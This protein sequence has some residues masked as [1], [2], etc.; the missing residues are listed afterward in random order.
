M[1]LRIP[2]SRSAYSDE[3]GFTALCLEQMFGQIIHVNVEKKV[4]NL[5]PLPFIIL[6]VLL[7]KFHI[8]F[9]KTFSRYS[10]IS[11][12]TQLFVQFQKNHIP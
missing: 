10:I 9:W 7:F 8:I 12:N 5:F 1:E 2:I 11:L 3:Y 6:C 4:L